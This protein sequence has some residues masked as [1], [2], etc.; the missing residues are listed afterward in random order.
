M[1]PKKII[2]SAEDLPLKAEQP[3]T[4]HTGRSDKANKPNTD[5]NHDDWCEAI[6]VVETNTKT[7]I[8]ATNQPKK[9]A[10]PSCTR[11]HRTHTNID[12]VKYQYDTLER[13][14]T[15]MRPRPPCI[16]HHKLF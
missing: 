2:R 3:Y 11:Q 13:L 1:V 8:L 14:S 9:T 5:R 16:T 6:E 7:S 12:E 10:F 4:V 15:A